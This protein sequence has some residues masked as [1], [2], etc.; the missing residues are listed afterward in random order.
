MSALL[1]IVDQDDQ[2][3]GRQASK[4]EAHDEKLIHRCVAVY[5]FDAQGRLYV[6]VH[7]KS[8]GLLDHSVGGHVD[9]GEDYATAA[10][11]EAD[12]ELGIRDVAFSELVTRLYSDEG[13]FIHM[14][15]IYECQPGKDWLFQS[16]EEVAEIIPYEIKDIIALM[17]A[18]PGRFTGGFINTMREYRRIKGI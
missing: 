1:D 13:T 4:Q 14:F 10:Y 17:E 16:N 18:S 12:E 11:R 3:I 7:K 2:L 6:Q 8:G 15:G 9:A 5:V